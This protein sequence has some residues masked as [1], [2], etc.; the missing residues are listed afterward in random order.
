MPPKYVKNET[1]KNNN[2]KYKWHVYTLVIKQI[3][4]HLLFR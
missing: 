1:K 3:I 4:L 2:K